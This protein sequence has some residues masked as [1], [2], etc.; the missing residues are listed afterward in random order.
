[1]DLE[2]IIPGILALLASIGFSFALLGRKKG[3]QKKLDELYRQLQTIGVKSTL[4]D[5]ESSPEKLKKQSWGNRSEG[6]I[7]VED[8]N[9]DY[10]NLISV[11]S[12]Y[13]VQYFLDYTV[14][15]IPRNIKGEA[16]KK[17]KMTRKK[18]ASI[19]GK[20]IDIKWK[21]DP[22]FSQRLNFDYE[23]K[24]KLEQADPSFHKGT[25][26][27]IPEPKN[28]YTRI[29][30]NY[31]LPTPDIFETIDNIALYIKSGI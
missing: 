31:Y 11:T 24:N 10:V 26:W 25:I 18:I 28:Q 17:T 27:I 20:K 6:I 19:S 4:M 30:T 8:K 15:R 14:M 23:L 16:I 12:Q 7:Q 13:S 5:K 2:D 21:G 1:M 9:I 22:F 3:G 29:R